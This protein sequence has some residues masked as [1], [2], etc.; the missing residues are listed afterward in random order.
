ML[1]VLMGVA[2]EYT[3][4]ERIGVKVPK[5]NIL[6]QNIFGIHTFAPFN[7]QLIAINQDIQQCCQWRG[8]SLVVE[9]FGFLSELNSHFKPPMSFWCMDN[10][11]FQGNIQVLMIMCTLINDIELTYCYLLNEKFEIFLSHSKRTY[12]FLSKETKIRKDRI[13]VLVSPIGLFILTRDFIR[14]KTV[15]SIPSF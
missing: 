14:N 13:V 1:H 9:I 5:P 4:I 3:Q 8:P 6:I 7:T 2:G 10:N 11:Q 15:I 12:E